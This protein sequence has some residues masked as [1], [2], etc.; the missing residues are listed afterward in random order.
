MTVAIITGIAVGLRLV[1][2]VSNGGL[3]LAVFRESVGMGFVSIIPIVGVIMGGVKYWQQTRQ[4]VLQYWFSFAMYLV[5]TVV[6]IAL[7]LSGAAPIVEQQPPPAGVPA[8][9]PAGAGT[10]IP[11]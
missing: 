8:M 4:Y 11:N 6:V 10:A 1:I 9:A 7:A 3:I 2:L 5:L